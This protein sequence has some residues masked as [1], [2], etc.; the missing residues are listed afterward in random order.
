MTQD[1]SDSSRHKIPNNRHLG[2]SDKQSSQFESS[3]SLEHRQRLAAQ[4]IAALKK[5]G[6]L[7]NSAS[8]VPQKNSTSQTTSGNAQISTSDA[9]RTESGERV[10]SSATGALYASDKSVVLGKLGNLASRVKKIGFLQSISKKVLVGTG[11]LA[12]LVM[13]MA[14]AFS[15]DSNTN[16][17]SSTTKYTKGDAEDWKKNSDGQM[18][19][20]MQ[21]DEIDWYFQV[22]AALRTSPKILFQKAAYG[23]VRID[24]GINA[25]SSTVTTK[26]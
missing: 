3:Q 6:Q 25:E 2:T 9:T 22:N 1:S 23:E 26:P 24:K 7:R 20:V 18:T 4:K 17:D 11:I 10:S 13:T 14:I 21:G 15:G 5:S 12:A 8:A 16:P 19:Y